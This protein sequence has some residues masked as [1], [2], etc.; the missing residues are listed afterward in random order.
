MLKF[1]RLNL[2]KNFEIFALIFLIL[3]ATLFT[4]Y[5]NY[6]KKIDKEI[7]INFIE[8]IYFQKT[9]KTVIE[10]LEPKFQKIKHKIQ[11]GETFDKILNDYDIDEK[12]ILKIKK[13]FSKKII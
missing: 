1:I 10:N 6:K 9:L 4:N 11:S 12:E 8:N 3:A 7:Y 5:F 13:S 2:K